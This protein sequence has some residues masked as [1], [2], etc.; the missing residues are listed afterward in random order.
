MKILGSSKNDFDILVI[1]R[2][3]LIFE[4]G[5]C[6]IKHWLIHNYIRKDTYQETKYLNEKDSL[7]IK[8]NGSYT[9]RG[10]LVDGSSTQYRLDKISIDKD[11]EE[12]IPPKSSSFEEK[13]ELPTKDK[14]IREITPRQQAIDY[15]TKDGE[16]DKVLEEFILKGYKKDFL[17]T[18]MKKFISYWTEMNATGRKQKWELQKTFEVKKRLIYWLNKNFK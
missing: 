2:F 12:E 5:I 10:R 17:L 6:V 1:K 15:F 11:R 4:N 14:D 16:K 3:I 7:I 9:E 13:E 18:E 8:E